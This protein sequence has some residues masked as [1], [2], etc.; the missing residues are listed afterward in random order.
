MA[1]TCPK[2]GKLVSDGLVTCYACGEFLTP[3]LK[4]AGCGRNNLA[5]RSNCQFCG[6]LLSAPASDPS[7]PIPTSLAATPDQS[8]VPELLELAAQHKQ[9]PKWSAFGGLPLLVFCILSALWFKL[10]DQL[11]PSPHVRLHEVYQAVYDW[12]E[13]AGPC[14]IPLAILE[15]L[16]LYYWVTQSRHRILF[17]GF[18]WLTL[19][20]SSAFLVWLIVS[21]VLHWILEFLGALV[22][23]R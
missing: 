16:A 17:F 1:I 4:C 9:P 15:V 21:V 7:A 10:M 18:N 3:P 19:L 6:N 22:G 13:V 23:V 20:G 8:T 5:G 14:L 12:K 11:P 2:C